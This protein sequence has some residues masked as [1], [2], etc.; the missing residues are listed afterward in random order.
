MTGVRASTTKR[1]PA[2]AAAETD[3]ARAARDYLGLG[4]SVVPVRG[5]TKLPLIPWEPY[6][7]QRADEADLAAWIR[8]WPDA[9]IGIATGA[10]SQIVVLDIDPAHG[11]EDS[12]ARL[13]QANGALPPTVEAMTGGG[14]RHF[15][16]RA[17]LQ[18]LRSRTGLA[19]G[20]DLRAEGGL[21]V[22]PPSIHPNGRRYAWRDGR[23]PQTMTPAALP[24]WLERLAGGAAELRGHPT[25][26]WRDL[27]H[28]GVDEGVRNTTLASLAGHLL[29]HGVDADIVT[30]MLLCWNR[31]RC[32]PPLADDEVVKV[33]ASISRLH[34]R[35]DAG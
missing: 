21:A 18:P 12:L 3:A 23:D 10:V 13:E 20:I 7:H 8:R 33:A 11:G 32:R 4:W 17:P 22:V 2:A 25:R 31:V 6:Q 14:G 27:I 35:G 19:Q 34:R 30:E 1:K 5:R 16:F 24:I 28:A 15:Y 29:W 9:N 26:Y